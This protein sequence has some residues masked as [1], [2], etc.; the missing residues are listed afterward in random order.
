MVQGWKLYVSNAECAGLIPGLGNKI[1]MQCGTVKKKKK[2]RENISQN[3]LK[4]RRK[5]IWWTKN[6]Y[7]SQ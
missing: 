1:P 2:I 4:N 7:V 3:T 5:E 6:D